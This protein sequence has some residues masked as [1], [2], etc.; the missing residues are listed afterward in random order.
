MDENFSNQV[1]ET[2][3]SLR[4]Q[5]ISLQNQ[6][7]EKEKNILYQSSA[8]LIPTTGDLWIDSASMQL[9]TYNGSSWVTLGAS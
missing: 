1:T 4:S 9:K 2:L 5:N 7:N 3:Q 6:I 8:P